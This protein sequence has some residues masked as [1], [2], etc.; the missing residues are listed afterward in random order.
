MS[1]A[2]VDRLEQQLSPEMRPL[3]RVLMA[4]P[5]APPARLRDE[6][7]R[8]MGELEAT[9]SGGPERAQAARISEACL[10]LLDRAEAEW[11]RRL[12]QVACR[13]FVSPDD[14][15]R[16]VL[17]SAGLL[18]DRQVVE[19]VASLLGREEVTRHTFGV[20]R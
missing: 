16:D 15:E 8:Y 10:A 12:V 2:L 1:E 4:Q 3:V 13:Y 18:D 20:R 19:A 17:S 11:E 9:G 7:A 6:I 5:L 14:A